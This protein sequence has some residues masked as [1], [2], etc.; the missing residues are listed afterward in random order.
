MIDMT[1]AKAR[2]RFLDPLKIRLPLPGLISI[3]HRV[4][5]AGLFLTLPVA[6]YV[7]DSSLASPQSFASLASGAGSP[8]VKLALLLVL[9]AFLHHFFAGIRY[10]LLDL[11][12]GI[13]LKPARG[14]A[15]VVLIVSLALT[16]ILGMKLW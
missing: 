16:V 11:Q 1:R 7:L 13:E 5:G 6:I 9:W 12:W 8:L 2:P 15:W 4:S 10:L 3:L 14:S